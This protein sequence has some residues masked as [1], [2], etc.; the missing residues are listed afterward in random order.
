[1]LSD[2]SRK[3]VEACRFCWMCRHLCPV[4]LVTG[5][6]SNGP[7]AKA[8]F[9]S[10]QERG[11]ELE[12]ETALDMYECALCNACA[13]N[14]ET[15]YEPAT[16]IRD[17]RSALVAKSLVPEK[18]Q[19]VIDHLLDTGS[20]YEA[21]IAQELAN[22]NN[23]GC[24]K[25]LVYAGA[26]AAIKAP[27]MLRAFLNL[28]GKAGVEYTLFTGGHSSAS[29]EYDLLGS[30]QE[31]QSVCEDCAK[32]FN[33]TS[34]DKIVVLDPADAVMFKQQYPIWGIKLNAAVETATAFVAALVKDSRL[35]PSK[36]EG[37]VTYHDPSRLARDLDETE[38]AR[39]IIASMGY[40]LCEMWQSRKLTR[41]CGGE[42]LATH[43]PE[44][45]RKMSLA[46]LEDAKR[47]G[48]QLVVAACP[49]SAAELAEAGTMPVAD[50]FTLLDR[51][52]D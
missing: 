45:V 52:T 37:K 32:A 19:K 17:A 43:S 3:T 30:V 47:T 22:F 9:I 50:V 14:C 1:M 49:Q 2:K 11:V 38:C 28:L 44:L 39:E 46:R 26:V 48:A 18:V 13:S 35:V 34:A 6:E 7:R 10:M 20:L 15:G 8:L 51:M 29:A 5:R 21:D 31:V 40:E 41:S 33:D 25:I 27:E 42:V 4:G 12:K 36:A 24:G 23:P 16:F